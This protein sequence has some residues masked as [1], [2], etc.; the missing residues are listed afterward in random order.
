MITVEISAVDSFSGD[1]KVQVG[2]VNATATLV[3]GKGNVTVSSESLAVGAVSVKVSSDENDT[4]LAGTAGT[5][6]NVTAKQDSGSGSGTGDKNGTNTN[7]TDKKPAATKITL[8]L[9]K[10]KVKKSAKKLVLRATLKINGK[11][12]KKGTK[13]VFKFKGK[14]YTA[15]VKAKGVAKVTIKKKVLKKLKVGKK[16]KYQVSYG[17]TVKK[18]SVKVKK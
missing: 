1:V 8:T 12:A 4:F 9:K 15:K 5:T 10:V 18:L 6:F 7:G 17:K 2:D 11:Y 3:N 13:V 16:V 14:K